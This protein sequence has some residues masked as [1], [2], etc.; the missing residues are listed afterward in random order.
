MKNTL[1]LLLIVLAITSTSAQ[2]RS[3]VVE[4]NAGIGVLTAPEMI[5]A[6]STAVIDQIVSPNITSLDITNGG[7]AYIGTVSFFPNGRFG[8]GADFVYDR[9]D[10]QANYSDPWVQ[11]QTTSVTYASLLARLDIRYIKSGFVRLYS[12]GALG[13]SMRTAERTDPL[14]VEKDQSTGFG[15][16]LT[17][18]GIRIGR[19][20]GA[21]AELGFGFRGLLSGGVSYQF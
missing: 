15:L 13:V 20:L 9:T 21:W 18:I 11:P 17:P 19:R 4:V 14:P 10:M 6:I 2:D 5:E 8:V 12:S 3:P 1:A 7:V 16:Q